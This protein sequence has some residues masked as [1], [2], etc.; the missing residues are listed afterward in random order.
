MKESLRILNKFAPWDA[1]CEYWEVGG[2]TPVPVNDPS[3][4]FPFGQGIHV[5]NC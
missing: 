4:I 5:T 1:K 2:S 3:A